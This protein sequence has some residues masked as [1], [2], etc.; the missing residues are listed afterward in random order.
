[1]WWQHLLSPFLAEF[2]WMLSRPWIEEGEWPCTWPKLLPRKR[3][4]TLVRCCSLHDISMTSQVVLKQD[5]I[6]AACEAQKPSRL[7]FATAALS[8]AV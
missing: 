7:Q 5:A 4:W 8:R 2:A 1:M 3:W 6:K